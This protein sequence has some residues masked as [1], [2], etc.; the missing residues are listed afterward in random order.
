[1][2]DTPA[3]DP[4]PPPQPAGL[5]PPSGARSDSD[6]KAL[7]IVAYALHLG[8]FATGGVTNL[9]AIIMDYVLRGDA[10]GWARTHYDFQIRTFWIALIGLLVATV[11]AIVSAPLIFLVVGIPMIILDV[12]FSVGLAVWFAVRCIIGL[13]HAAD[14]KPYPR[15]LTWLA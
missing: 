7:V 12:L 11:V 1:M 4:L 6:Q 8:G 10:T 15:P 2:T 13:I 3:A 9:I 5:P 14:S